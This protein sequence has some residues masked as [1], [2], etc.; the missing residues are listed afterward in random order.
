[1]IKLTKENEGKAITQDIILK[2]T[3]CQLLFT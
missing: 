2:I 3:S 1:L